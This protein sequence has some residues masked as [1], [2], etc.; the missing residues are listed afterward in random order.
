MAITPSS[1]D[2]FKAYVDYR[3]ENLI[4]DHPDNCARYAIAS[5]DSAATESLQDEVF[6]SPPTP[7]SPVSGGI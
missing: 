5:I 6:T 2:A 1:T 3:W 4:R 7:I